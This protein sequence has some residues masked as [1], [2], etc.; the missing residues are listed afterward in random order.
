MKLRL[1]TSFKKHE[2][3]NGYVFE[4][5]DV[6]SAKAHIRYKLGLTGPQARDYFNKAKLRLVYIGE[7]K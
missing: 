6:I 2:K 3:F 1:E 7:I 4:A 5:R